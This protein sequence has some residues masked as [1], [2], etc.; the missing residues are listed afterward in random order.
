MAKAESLFVVA[1]CYKRIWFI[2]GM[3]IEEGMRIGEGVAVEEG[4]GIGEGAAGCGFPG[5]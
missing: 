3:A 2:Q 1:C 5:D 4:E